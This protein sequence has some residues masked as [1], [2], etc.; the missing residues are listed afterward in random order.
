M[1]TRQYINYLFPIL[2]VVILSSCGSNS[3]PK[4]SNSTDNVAEI[5]V[6]E[7]EIDIVISEYPEIRINEI[8]TKNAES[9]Y[10]WI[11]LHITSNNAVNL[12]DFSL[13][14]DSTEFSP[15]PDISLEPGSFYIIYATTDLNTGLE[16]VNFKLG[17]SDNVSLFKGDDL[18]DKISW[19]KGEA[20]FGS[21]FGRFPDGSDSTQTLIPTASNENIKATLRD[22]VISEV[23]ANASDD[24]NDWFELLNTS[25]QEIILSEYQI[26]N[27]NKELDP[28]TLPDIML[29]AGQYQK[30]IASEIDPG[31]AYVPFQLSSSDELELIFN[32][33][34]IYYFDWKPSDV[35]KGF[36]YGLSIDGNLPRKTLIPTPSESNR[37]VIVFNESIVQSLSIE[38]ADENWQDILNNPLDKI[39]HR[40]S[41]TFNGVTLNEIAIRTKGSSS[42]TSVFNSGGERFSFKF[43]INEYVSGQK[44]FG[45]KKFVLNN[46]FHDPSY[47]RE[48]IAYDLLDEMGV[49]VPK[50]AYVNFYV[51]G[52]LR[53]LYLMLETI[54]KTFLKK[55]FG[56]SQGDLYK[57][58]GVGSDLRWIDNEFMSYPGVEL[59]TNKKS[60]DNG[61]FVNFVSEMSFGDTNSVIDIDSVLR[62]MAV[63][64]SLSNLDSYHGPHDHNYYIYEQDGIFSFLPW[65]LNESF[66]TFGTLLTCQTQD[67][68]E[69]T[70]D[71]PTTGPLIEK[72]LLAKLFS[73]PIHLE[74]YHNYLWELI[75]G[76]LS[77]PA[78]SERV[79]GL[80]NLIREHVANDPTSFYNLSDFNKNINESVDR[81]YGLTSFIE[82]RR[83][84]MIRQLSGEIDPTRSG[85]GFCST[86]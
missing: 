14:K 75:N 81:F 28:V 64:V 61:A 71:E 43:D 6:S 16:T 76:S 69:L 68:R 10:S 17:N 59:K 60:S 12:S 27:K 74:T 40:A 21:S 83:D 82:Y 13:T 39:Y 54:D 48:K 31:E 33:E 30:I 23:V 46:S 55:H 50:H 41:L 58:D 44:L 70:I 67:I 72:P 79:N 32:G 80:A 35:P 5:P 9:E 15:L 52:E 66:G 47:M 18:I 37:N 24:S 3:S 26:I 86:F 34:S 38:I 56:N 7:E 73:N 63:S 42:L 57:P 8:I 11:E 2:L 29:S 62:Y 19:K 1:N 53:G 20:L 36:S 45:L 77:S 49:V 51:N 22:L 25:D 4:K 85:N 84:N 65:D 78:F